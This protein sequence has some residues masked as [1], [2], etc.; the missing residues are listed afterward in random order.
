MIKKVI[1]RWWW[2]GG[3]VWFIL[4]IIELLQVVLLC[5]T[6]DCGKLNYII[7]LNSSLLNSIL[8]IFY[9]AVL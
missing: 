2:C 4:S 9:F 8:L 6:L 3:L 5:S 1:R 7:L